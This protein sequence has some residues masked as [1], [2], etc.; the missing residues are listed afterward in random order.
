[1]HTGGH[2]YQPLKHHTH[3]Q[4]GRY[5]DIIH[6]H[7]LLPAITKPSRITSH[8]ATLLDHISTNTINSL[9]PTLIFIG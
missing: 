3:Q 9:Y 7:E 8:I 4:A 5:L 2:E 6:S 1:M